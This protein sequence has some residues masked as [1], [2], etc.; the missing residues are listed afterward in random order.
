[1]KKLPHV[2]IIEAGFG[3]LQAA[4]SL[5][6]TEVEVTLI[7]RHNYHT[8]TPL[9]YQVATAQLSPEQVTIPVRT[10]LRQAN[11]VRF[12]QAEVQQIDFV[13]KEIKTQNHILN[14]DFLVL[15]TGTQSQF[16]EIPGAKSDAFLLKTLSHAINLRHHL[17]L[18]KQQTK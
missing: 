10:L 6:S 15:A 7:D 1:M 4:Q 16:W 8:F 9:L 13:A 18:S 11:H 2:I 5:A 17:V 3:G 12:L 14:Y